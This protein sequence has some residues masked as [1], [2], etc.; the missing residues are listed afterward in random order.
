[1]LSMFRK[2]D[3]WISFPSGM[4]F[5]GKKSFLFS[6]AGLIPLKEMRF[7]WL[8]QLSKRRLD[9]KKGAIR[10]N[11]L[12][13]IRLSIFEEIR[14]PQGE[15]PRHPGDEI[16]LEELSR[17]ESHRFLDISRLKSTL[18]PYQELGVQWLWF[19]YCHGLSGLL[20]DDMGLGKTHQAMA[21]LAG[22]RHEDPECAYKYM[23]VCPT[24]VIYHWQELLRRFLPDLRVCVFYGLTRTLENFEQ[25]Y[26]LLLTSYG[27]L[28]TGSDDLRSIPF[29]IAIYDE[30][31]IAKNHNSQTHLA[32][33]GVSAHMRLGLT[34]TP[35]ENR[36]REL[37]ALFD[38]VLP[39]YLPGDAIFRELFT[40][41]IEK[42]RTPRKKLCSP[43]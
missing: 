5:Q 40:N 36:L 18:R 23:V 17:F 10:L 37:K 4:R 25:N 32:L 22:A 31:Q 2:P 15:D 24:S 39:S 14:P 20:C 42:I 16:L 13:W 9:R 21:L 30:I 3:P 28:R 1:M 11:I 27:I 35:I 7:N 12:E 6:P 43:A 29:E 33:R 26:D 34:G 38:V 41:P 19:L 8:R